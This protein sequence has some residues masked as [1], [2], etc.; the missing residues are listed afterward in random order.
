MSD[1][2]PLSPPLCPNL[3]PESELIRRE[4]EAAETVLPA[5]TALRI[6]DMMSNSGSENMHTVTWSELGQ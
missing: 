1:L 2:Q 6:R 5:R 3:W 4:S